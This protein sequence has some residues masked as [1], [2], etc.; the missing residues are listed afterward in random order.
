MLPSMIA[1][2][3]ALDTVLGKV[4]VNIINP[5]IEFVFIIATVI[6]LWG[7]LQFMI[8]AAD[9]DKREEGKQHMLWGFV[10]FLIMFGVYGII[11]ILTNTFEITGL[12]LNSKQQTF[13]PP[14]IQT[15][16]IPQ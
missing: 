16:K 2:A 15:L 14:A 4:Y 5:A 10:G 11:T 13:T 1:Y 3:D 12:T 8:G 7:V 6:F 9:K